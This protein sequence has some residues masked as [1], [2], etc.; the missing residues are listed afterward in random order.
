MSAIDLHQHLWPDRVAE[1]LRG[2]TRAPYLRGWTLHTAGDAP[3]DVDPADHDVER[4]V[5]L[6]HDAGVGL[7]CVSLSA[8]LGIEELP[9]AEATELIDAWHASASELPRHVGA[10]VSVP[11]LEP[12][13]DELTDLLGGRFVGVQLPA[14]QLATPDAWA[15]VGEVLRVAEL[16][17]RPVLVHPGPAA[18]GSMP[19]WWAPVVGYVGQ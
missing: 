10:W 4:R 9:R 5:V 12:D 18:S 19:A 13:V 16:A 6:D 1:L 3:Y 2:R 11:A 14:T 17:G 7:A 8:P 15:R